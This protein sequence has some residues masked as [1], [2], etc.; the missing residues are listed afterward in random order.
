[1][2]ATVLHDMTGEWLPMQTAAHALAVSVDTIKRRVKRG[3]LPARQEPTVSGFRWL[4]YVTDAAPA[5][6]ADV[7]PVQAAPVAPAATPAALPLQPVQPDLAPLAAVIERLA[8]QNAQ[9]AA[10]CGAL[11]AEVAVVRAQL[12][13]ARAQLEAGLTGQ[14]GGGAADVSVP[15]APRPWWAFWRR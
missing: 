2:Q 14:A 12:A 9:L 5:A 3:E 8:V 15:G 1:M 7:P 11:E 10:R 13:V 4:V 6:P